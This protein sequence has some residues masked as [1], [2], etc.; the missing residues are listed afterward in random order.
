[1]ANGQDFDLALLALR[2][3]PLDATLQSP[4]EILNGRKYRSTLPSIPPGDAIQKNRTTRRR[5]QEKQHVGAKYYNRNVKE[6]TELVPGQC[7]RLFDLNRKV[8]EPATVTGFADTPRS[9]IVQ[10]L[11]GGVP[12]RR[13]RIHIRTTKE[14]WDMVT[15][16]VDDTAS[17]LSNF[18]STSGVDADVTS[19]AV[20]HNHDEH[21]TM[22]GKRARKQTVF[23]Q[24]S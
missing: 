11:E 1:M 23:Y 16:A 14:K 9:Y 20:A 6:K 2:A 3:T 18:G 21:Q 12:L 24:S 17:R 4:G 10:R 5:L 22:Q 13:N 19:P 7:V 15:P 8:W